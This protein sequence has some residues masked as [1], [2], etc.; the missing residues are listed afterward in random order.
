MEN[1]GPGTTYTYVAL[2]QDISIVYQWPYCVLSTINRPEGNLTTELLKHA[3]IT[4]NTK[5]RY[6]MFYFNFQ[7]LRLVM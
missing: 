1:Y 6:D 4:W 3:L 5:Y 2:Y 7:P